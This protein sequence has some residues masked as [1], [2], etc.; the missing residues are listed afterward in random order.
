MILSVTTPGLVACMAR[1][2]TACLVLAV[3][4]HA[5]AASAQVP[6]YNS[7]Q[8]RIEQIDEVHWRFTGQVEL[9]NEEVKGQK[10]YANLVDLYT[11][12]HRVEASGTV[13]YET[14]TARVAAER[15]IFNTRTGTGTFFNASG[16]AA[17]Q[18]KID[19]SMFGALEPDVF[20][21]G[22]ILEKTGEDRYKI[23]KGGFT[24]CVQPTP[25]WELVAGSVSIHVGDY[26][27]LKNAVMH[28]KDVPVFYLPILYYPI[29]DDDRATGFL[30][31]TYGVSRYQGQS[32]SNAFFW[33][34]NRSQDLT[35]LHDWF[36]T[37]GQ[38]YG[39]EYRWIRTATSS[40]NIRAYRLQQKAATV[41]GIAVP[42]SRSVLVNGNISQDLPFKLRGRARIDY[43]S[44]FTLNQLY[45]RDIYAATLSQSTVNGNVS[46]SWRFLNASLTGSRQEQFVNSDYSIVNGSQPSL[47]AAVSNTRL[48]RL[49]VYF[50]LQSEASRPV[51]VIHDGDQDTDLTL[52]KMDLTPTLRAPI[53]RWPFLNLTLNASYRTTWYSQSLDEATKSIQV[54][55]PLLRQYGEFRADIVGPTF[56]KVFTPNNAIAD[57]LKH[58]I[59]PAF[60][61]QRVTSIENGD[62]VP[63]QGY[64]YDRVVGDVTRLTY[65]LTN[66]V[67]VRKASGSQGT[68]SA[69]AA[70][71]ELLTASLSQSYYTDETASQ[72]DPTYASSNAAAG[73]V[74][75]PSHYSPVAVN[76]RSSP[77]TGIGATFR[78]E[79]DASTSKFLSLSTGGDYTAGNRQVAVS[80]IKSL[81]SIYPT[82]SLNGSTRLT[83]LDGRVGAN[84]SINWDIQRGFILQQKA[85]GHYNAQCCGFLVEYQEFNFGG[86]SASPI[87][88]DRRFNL[89]FTLAGIGT[90]SNFF[91]AFGG[92]SY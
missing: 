30:L 92:S 23:T 65:G 61:V 90:F 34:I 15:A 37:T 19:K 62:R 6:G 64:L 59:E 21:Y 4:L 81:S 75:E 3:L 35:V 31:P 28:V 18:N 25:R 12:T 67:L 88:K 1:R 77:M 53:S 74:R 16:I 84:Y 66:R 42:E 33:A 79:Y 52:S 27:V 45:S 72:F 50:A 86:F 80:W 20:F 8:F 60:S 82:N 91:G 71:R 43:S 17:I 70:P 55:E 44:N 24:T 29:Q 87:A 26:A 10:F 22:E 56:S 76:V 5:A 48:G 63:K 7:K 89:A 68:A 47:T 57:R 58:V 38:G 69:A 51:Y 13:V 2:S 40:G 54:D 78:T 46:G 9:E 11:D 49:P 36:T 85:I 14:A 41:N 32:I 39:T 83:F 73:G